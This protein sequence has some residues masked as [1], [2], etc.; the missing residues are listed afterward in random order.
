[1]RFITPILGFFLA[2]TSGFY[3]CTPAVPD[4]LSNKKASRLL[5]PDGASLSKYQLNYTLDPYNG[6]TF[7]KADTSFLPTL[8]FFNN[9]EFVEYDRYNFYE[10]EWK[11]N[12]EK[13]KIQFK[14]LRK[15]TKNAPEPS[16]PQAVYWK[17]E[18][19][20][21]EF[22]SDSLVMGAQGRHGIVKM[23]YQRTEMSLEDE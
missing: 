8:L 1:M 2:C 22:K 18:Y 7:I 19:K 16:N 12:A 4:T 20:L 5:I 14:Y 15:N 21:I 6:G 13:D 23:I 3:S 9:G 11:V 17:Q 10:G